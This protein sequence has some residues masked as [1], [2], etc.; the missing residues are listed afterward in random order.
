MLNLAIL[1]ALLSS[2]SHS[3]VNEK[4]IVG[5]WYR[6]D[7][8]MQAEHGDKS[9][10][11]T[12]FLKVEFNSNGNMSYTTSWGGSLDVTKGLYTLNGEELLIELFDKCNEK[13]IL[14]TVILNARFSGEKLELLNPEHGED[15]E[16]GKDVLSPKNE[17][18][19]KDFQTHSEGKTVVP[20]Q[21]N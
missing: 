8:Y 5:T 11:D 15:I 17:Q 9:R 2:F 4:S 7:F 21:R 19:E 3:K 1:V 16:E 10:V 18:L 13:N 20:C 14:T 12:A 6:S